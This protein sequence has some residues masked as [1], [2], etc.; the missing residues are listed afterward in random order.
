MKRLNERLDVIPKGKVAYKETILLHLKGEYGVPELVGIRVFNERDEAAHVIHY[1]HDLQ[2]QEENLLETGE[3]DRE[4]YKFIQLGFMPL[5]EFEIEEWHFRFEE[6]WVRFIRVKD[7]G[8]FL[9]VERKFPGEDTELFERKQKKAWKFLESLGVK[10]EQ[11]L[12]VDV[13]GLIVTLF[14]QKLQNLGTQK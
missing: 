10:R 7:M 13:R 1:G 11:L 12:D 4:M 9:V 2:N 3:K 6:F 8:S 5:G 14:L